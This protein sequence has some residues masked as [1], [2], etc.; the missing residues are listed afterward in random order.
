[1]PSLRTFIFYEGSSHSGYSHPV[2]RAG[3]WWIHPPALAD[4]S[5]FANGVRYILAVAAS[6]TSSGSGCA[7]TCQ[8]DMVLGN[9]IIG[10]FALHEWTSVPLIASINACVFGILLLLSLSIFRK[11]T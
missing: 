3:V 6:A 10:P 9:A 8:P 2:F 5:I 1:M 7:D 11:L 4:S